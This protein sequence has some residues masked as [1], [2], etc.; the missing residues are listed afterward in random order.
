[1]DINHRSS[2]RVPLTLTV[3][4]CRRG[5]SIGRFVTRNINPFGAFIEMPEE[6]L[7]TD[8]FVEMSFVDKECSIL[9][10][11]LVKHHDNKGVGVLFAYDF[12]EFRAMLRQHLAALNPA[13]QYPRW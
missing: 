5:K 8:D 11:G 4:I 10:K 1:M 13:R 2:A 6:A 3:T 9:Q 12:A 7:K